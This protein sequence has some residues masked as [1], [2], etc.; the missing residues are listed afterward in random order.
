MPRLKTDDSDDEDEQDKDPFKDILDDRRSEGREVVDIEDIEDI[1]EDDD[2]GDTE[3]EIPSESD[4]GAN[5]NRTGERV[6][7]PQD[8]WVQRSVRLVRDIG[9]IIE[10]SSAKTKST[11]CQLSRK[12]MLVE[13][14][15]KR[16]SE[17]DC[18]SAR[19]AIR[20]ELEHRGQNND[21]QYAF[22][23]SVKAAMREYT[24]EI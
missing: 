18:N 12:P 14:F 5:E 6:P 3:P 24:C 13:S 7:A 17:Q 21:T 22:K 19:R 9:L 1:E 23:M 10:T 16:L 2:T 11:A 4:L 15:S 8:D 20:R